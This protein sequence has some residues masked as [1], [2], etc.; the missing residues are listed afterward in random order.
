MGTGPN[1]GGA[2]A[3]YQVPNRG[4][5]A[6]NDADNGILNNRTALTITGWVK[7]EPGKTWDYL[8][9]VWAGD[10]GQ[11][12]NIRSADSLAGNGGKIE[13]DFR[14]GTNTASAL[15][16]SNT[17]NWNLDNQWMFFAVS[18]DGSNG[19]VGMYYVDGANQVQSA[20]AT[21]VN[22]TNAGTHGTGAIQDT[23]QTGGSPPATYGV[24]LGN[25][26]G[27]ALRPFDGWLD[28]MRVFDSVLNT[29]DLQLLVNA[30][31]A[32]PEPA[33]GL[34]LALGGAALAIFRR[35]RV[36]CPA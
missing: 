15:V 16:R 20:G 35:R 32:V 12:M 19:A 1:G 4:P 11:F 33:G 14:T 10:A 6:T 3:F 9:Q 8:S 21:Y 25:Q 18:W 34:L 13:F 27:Y 17:A 26:A 5:R 22:G 29:A 23:A 31:L 36:S 30:D 24:A 7:T 2:N 28:N